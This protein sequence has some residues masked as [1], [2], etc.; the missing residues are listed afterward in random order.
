MLRL[1]VR[2]TLWSILAL[3]AI[4]AVTYLAMAYVALIRMGQVRTGI[5]GGRPQLVSAPNARIAVAPGEVVAV[6]RN[7]VSGAMRGDLGT[8][9]NGDSVAETVLAAFPRSLLLL[10]SAVTVAAVAGIL[11]GY[12]SLDQGTRRAR[13]VAFWLNVVGYSAPAFYVGILAI[14]SLIL[15]ARATGIRGLVLP[16]VGY[17]LDRHLILPVLA[18]ALRPTAEIARL[19]SESLAAE[20][21]LPYVRTGEAK[22]AGWRRLLWRHAWPNV[23]APVF[24]HLGNTVRYLVGSLVV[25]ELLFNWPGVGKLLATAVAPRVDGRPSAQVLYSP[26]L[27]AATVTALAALVIVIGFIAA[28]AAWRS[29][30]RLRR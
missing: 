18:L 30:P 10:A 8:L 1:I 4:H 14:Q 19:T 26:D 12:L 17:G 15:L 23:A 21:H 13:A 16:A 22:G 25:V 7:Y 5:Y 3:Y 11:I 20:L 24:V 27:V 2:R 28:V 29:D 6:Y 9:Q